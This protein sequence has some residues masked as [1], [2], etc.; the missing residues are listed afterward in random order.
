MYK[1]KDGEEVMRR[2]VAKN[3]G[4]KSMVKERARLKVR[5]KT[6]WIL[7]TFLFVQASEAATVVMVLD[8]LYVDFSSVQSLQL[9]S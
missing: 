2:R 9:P 4:Q 5:D 8:T 6:T 1:K 7:T 3:S